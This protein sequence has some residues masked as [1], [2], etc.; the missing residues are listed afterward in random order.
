[1]ASYTKAPV[2]VLAVTSERP[3]P[4]NSGGHLRTFHLINALARDF[5]VRLLYPSCD[6]SEPDQELSRN[7]DFHC[8]PVSVARRSAGREA[9]RW[10]RAQWVKEPYA[11]YRRHDRPEVHQAVGS[12]L[13]SFDPHVV[14]L[15][16]LDSVLYCPRQPGPLVALD[17]HNIYSLILERFANE[18]SGPKRFALKMDAARLARVEKRACKRADLVCAV[19][20]PEADHFVNLDAKQ[21]ALIS[22][23][24][25]CDAVP[26]HQSAGTSQQPRLLFLGAMDWSPNISA[27][28]FLAT[29]LLP[30]LRE[31]FPAMELDL[32]GRNPTEQVVTLGRLA[33]VNVTGT[34]PEVLPY[35]Q[36]ATLFVVPL[37][38]GGGTRLK[39]LEAFA[40]GVP[41]VSTRVGA[42]GI[43][44]EDGVHLRLL[45]RSQMAD[46]I[47]ELLSGDQLARMA[48][49][50]RRLAEQRYHWGRIGESAV[51]ALR[52][53]LDNPH[54]G[55]TKNA[56]DV[57]LATDSR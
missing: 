13:E 26:F 22:N 36:R 25:D 55:R 56:D 14:W 5:E 1:M 52:S 45:E 20:Q 28:Q 6:E 8:R 31:R 47:T 46:G 29:E 57:S 48:D 2:R 10:G 24:V 17:L 7:A 41:V 4:L 39:I 3:W 23:G 53:L 21:V 44:A 34:V 11:M 9:W 27:A 16:H 43:D 38:S 33:G 19:S 35:L 51:A 18:S 54:E 37:D 50:A 30:K 49:A 40:A 32:V 12:Q 42:E 15:D